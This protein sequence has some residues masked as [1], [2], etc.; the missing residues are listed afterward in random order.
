MNISELIVLA[1]NSLRNS[2][3]RTILTMLGIIIGIASVIAIV[4][5][6]DGAKQSVVDQV[7]RL[8]TDIIT[9]S[10]GKQ[11]MG[12]VMSGSS[13]SVTTE[14]YEAIL[15]ANLENV[16]DATITVSTNKTIVANKISSTA[17]IVGVEGNY[18]E[19]YDLSIYSGSFISDSQSKTTSRI[20]MI[21]YTVAEELFGEGVDPIGEKIKIGTSNYKII[22]MLEEVGQSSIASP[23]SSIYI[24]L[25]CA[26]KLLTGNEN[27]D[28]IIVSINDSEL[29]EDTVTVI[30]NFM[31]KQHGL[32][33]IDDADFTVTS[34]Q[35]MVSALTDI[36]GTLTTVLAVVAAISLL[37]G[38]IGIMNIM[39][40]T[41][42]E[43]TREIGLLK[44][45]GA[46]N[47]NILMQFLIESIVV[48]I[49]GGIIGTVIGIIFSYIASTLMGLP[50]I[51]GLGPIL[52]SVIISVFIGV[53]FGYYP[54]QKAAKLNPIDAL[55]FE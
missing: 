32:T 1:F 2:L 10:S 23:D 45:I 55:R 39:M 29:A 13:D 33:S 18:D 11:R 53:L 41:V 24:P 31:L 44:A 47:N 48:T 35:E 6:G 19:I 50:F 34:S 54:A 43:R 25:T 12:P 51:I 9:I 27:P 30:E 38:G 21:G 7:S 42:T 28:N 22:G 14:D 46:A 3:F 49:S 40:V 4:S 36:T 17:S 15:S 20:A 52:I 16:D 26:M 8:G 5:V 37:V